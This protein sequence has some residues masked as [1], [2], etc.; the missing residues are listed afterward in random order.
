MK[1]LHAIVWVLAFMGVVACSAA[2]SSDDGPDTAATTE[3]ISV[4]PP[5]CGPRNCWAMCVTCE[6]DICL[7]EGG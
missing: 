6:Y 3:A 1:I 7:H 5:R 4:W 2:T